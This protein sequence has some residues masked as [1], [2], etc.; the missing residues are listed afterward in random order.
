M[1]VDGTVVVTDAARAGEC[2]TT[3]SSA[4][5]PRSRRLGDTIKNGRRGSLSGKLT[6]K[7]I[8]GHIAYPH[9][10]KNPIHLAAPA[11]ATLAERSSGTKATRSSRRPPGRS[12]TSTA[13]P[14]PATSSRAASSSTSTS[15]SAPPAP[16]SSCRRPLC[17]VLDRRRPG[18]RHRLD[19]RRQ[20]LPHR[21]RRADRRGAAGDRRRNR[22]RSRA[23]DHRRH[24]GRPLH[25]RHLSAG[26]RDRPGQC[27][28]PQGQRMRR[29][30]R[31]AATGRDLSPHHRAVAARPC[32]TRPSERALD[33][34][35]PAALR[36]QPLQR[37]Q[38]VL[39]SRLR[40]R[41]GRS[42]LSAAAQPAPAA[43][44]ARTLSRREADQRRTRRRAAPHRTPGQANGCRSPT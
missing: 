2:S 12:R 36:R 22:H 25:R 34:A 9:L 32:L 23:V 30:G 29:S 37:G 16:R 11:I 15:A 43:R 27:Q 28:H 13:A 19:A 41:L 6:V 24:L 39:R 10:A 44:P 17:D 14:A 33:P 26:G 1:R 7:G 5:R 4:N 20:T 18:L 21:Q 8:Q 31:P 35:R 38:A 3:A 42:R 40:Q